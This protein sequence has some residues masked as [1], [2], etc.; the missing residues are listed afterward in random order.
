MSLELVLPTL[1]ALSDHLEEGVLAL[2]AHGAW[3][4]EAADVVETSEPMRRLLQRVAHA[5]WVLA[6]C[7]WK[8]RS[9][10][11]VW[12]EGRGGVPVDAST[13]RPA[14][15]GQQAA[16]VYVLHGNGAGPHAEHGNTP[17]Q[18]HPCTPPRRQEY[19]S[20][21]PASTLLPPAA[22]AA[23][24]LQGSAPTPTV[25]RALAQRLAARL[26]T[27]YVRH[28]S[29]LRP[30][31][32][33]GALQLAKDAGE[34]EAAAAQQLAPL[35]ALQAPVGRLRAFRRALF[36]DAAALGAGAAAAAAGG[37][38]GVAGGKAAG[39]QAGELP[40]SVVLH[41]LFSRAP[42]AVASPHARQGL[43][44][45]Q[46]RK[47]EWWMSVS[48][49]ARKTG[50]WRLLLSTVLLL[51]CDILASVAIQAGSHSITV[52]ECHFFPPKQLCSIPCGWTTT[53]RRRRW[54]SSPRP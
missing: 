29:L 17:K 45:A 5:R 30:V 10:V 49:R 24:N 3:R 15:G 43:T 26:L 7:F 22:S 40:P 54:R 28:A 18:A 14:K 31:S 4:A 34:L 32:H 21:F 33:A 41:L 46:A 20:R 1:S 38:K 8:G 6:G 53:R 37:G 39:P 48:H 44:P 11:G 19:L 13:W 36:M 42:A 27:V 9:A 2:H 47:T 12:G 23:G 25:P 52:S 50:V 35:D 51:P 16:W